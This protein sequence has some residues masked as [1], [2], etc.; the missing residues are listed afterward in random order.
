MAKEKKVSKRKVEET[1]VTEVTTEEVTKKSKKHK[2]EKRKVEDC[3][4]QD[5]RA[6][7][8]EKKSK[9]K[10][11]KKKKKSKKDKKASS[12]EK[13]ESPSHESPKSQE[14]SDKNMKCEKVDVKPDSNSAGWTDWNKTSFG[15]DAAR[16]EKFL[17][18]MGAKKPASSDTQNEAAMPTKKGLFGSLKSSLFQPKTSAGSYGTSSLSEQTQQK[19]Q[20]DL[21]HQFEEGLKFKKNMQRGARRGLGA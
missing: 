3:D 19:I 20:S 14:A 17:K 18:L 6:T 2:K 16:K 12:E 15:G 4:D 13:S 5:S 7:S 11:E 1:L 8:K 9:H 21:E 10:S